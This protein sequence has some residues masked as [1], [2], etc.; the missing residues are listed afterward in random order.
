[1]QVCLC[2]NELFNRLSGTLILRIYICSAMAILE[3]SRNLDSVKTEISSIVKDTDG[4]PYSSEEYWDNQQFYAGNSK[5]PNGSKVK[6]YLEQAQKQDT[7]EDIKNHI[8]PLAFYVKASRRVSS[9][10]LS[11]H[12]HYTR[13]KCWDL[14]RIRM[15]AQGNEISLSA[16]PQTVELWTSICSESH[17]SATDFRDEV[18][19]QI[20]DQL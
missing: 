5:V 10:M 7:L 16:G 13:I 2:D 3:T 12:T 17:R 6:F 11:S 4:L 9:G 1:M 19:K 14:S 18:E 8:D 20:E 15:I